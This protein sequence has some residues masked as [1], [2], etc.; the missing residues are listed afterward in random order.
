MPFLCEVEEVRFEEVV[1]LIVEIVIYQQKYAF[2]S[3]IF[4]ENSVNLVLLRLRK[5][6]FHNS[7]DICWSE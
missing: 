7:S 2:S 4:Y 5:N 1:F 6:D 3:L